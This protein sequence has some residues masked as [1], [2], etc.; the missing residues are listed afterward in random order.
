MA[1]QRVDA[2]NVSPL[3]PANDPVLRALLLPAEY[4]ISNVA[5]VG[6]ARFFQSLRHRLA[7]GLKLVQVREKS[8]PD[9]ELAKLA[10]QVVEVAHPYGARVL[11]NGSVEAAHAAGADGIQLTERQLLALTQRPS[12]PL[13]G[14]SCHGTTALRRAESLGVDFAVLGPVKATPTHPGSTPLGWEGFEAV[15]SNA[16]IPVYA[17]GGLGRSDLETAWSHG[18]HGLA[19]VRGSWDL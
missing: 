17:I 6:E 10:R 12:L 7:E 16:A 2:L 19:M 9:A 1:W 8:L 14:A 5:S 18:A 13:V 3:L 15:A 4:A 11:V